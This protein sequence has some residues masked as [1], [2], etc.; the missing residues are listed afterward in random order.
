MNE[1]KYTI[2]API[3]NIVAPAGSLTEQELR[4][5]GVSISPEPTWQEKFEKDSIESVLEYF[6]AAEYVVKKV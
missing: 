3:G 6:R 5:F 1:Q 2:S 4:N